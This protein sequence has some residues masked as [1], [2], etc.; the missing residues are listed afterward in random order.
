LARGGLAAALLGGVLSA[1]AATAQTTGGD[2]LR[3]ALAAAYATNPTLG[4]ARENQKATDEGVPLARANGLPSASATAT[5]T[6]FIVQNPL[7]T[8]APKRI[9]AFTG[10]AAMPVYQG[11]AVRNAIH[12][13]ETRVTAGKASLAST[14]AQV[15]SSVVTA[16]MDVILDA[17]T[18]HFNQ[19]NVDQLKVN[20]Q[21]TEDRFQIGDLTRTDVAQSQ[22]RLATAEGQLQSAE[23]SL[24]AARENYIAIVGHAPGQLAPPP[25]LP[26]L[27]TSAEAAEA[28]ALET[29]P[30]L[31]AARGQA[32]AANYD[33]RAARGQRL[34]KLSL[35]A[36][37]EHDSYLGS[38]SLGELAGSGFTGPIPNTVNTADVGVRATIPLYS[39]GA[40]SATLRQAEAREGAAQDQ[41]IATER[42]VI[43]TVR[44]DFSQWLAA[45]A[46]IRSSQ[47]ALDAARLSLE[48]VKAENSV[49][50]RTIIEV[51]NAEQEVLNAEV[52][53]VTAERNAYV[54]GF[55]LLAS[56][57]LASARALNLD[58][59]DDAVPLYDPDLHYRRA[60]HDLSDWNSDGSPSIA[61]PL[62]GASRTVDSPVQ[63]GATDAA[64]PGG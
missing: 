1:T 32:V 59:G 20:L 11:G 57:G 31:L 62:T 37:A 16:Y 12:A 54:A 43:S 58:Q 3:A 47:T 48:G 40:P 50:N 42:T 39:G 51:L 53:L 26:H 63:G 14:E 25:A 4:A 13:A 27:P 52:G 30:D 5:E 33:T 55:N 34:P 29:N 61:T 24:A 38:L 21:S 15:F 17:E 8:P 7:N 22:S 56:M 28:T 35:F 60:G 23:A 41:A 64:K 19:A 46:I 36:D 44:A 2:S 6:E 45:G 10:T 49:G 9:A 18:V